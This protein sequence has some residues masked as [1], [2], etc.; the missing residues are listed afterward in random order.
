[1]KCLQFIEKCRLEGINLK[2]IQTLRDAEYQGTLFAQGRTIPGKIVTNCDGIK[3][4]S[5]HQSGLAWDC[6]PLDS[7]GNIIWSND[8]IY[9]KMADIAGS[10]GIRAGYYFRS[11]KDSPH[12]EIKL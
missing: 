2:I 4:K 3:S 9:K 10:I 8:A 7:K 12:F 11:F 1:M 6:V 5:N